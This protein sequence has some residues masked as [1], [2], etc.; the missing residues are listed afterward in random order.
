MTLIVRAIDVGYGYTKFTTAHEGREIR[1]A[2]FPSLAYPAS[3]DPAAS[4]GA[5]RRR[6]VAIPIGPLF[7]EVGPDVLLAADTFRAAQIHDNYIDTPEYLA[8]VR[9]ALRLMKVDHI[10]LLVVGLPVALFVT[11]KSRLEK[12]MTGLHDLGAGKTVQVHKALAM[13]Q[14]NGALIDF[15]TQQDRVVAMEHEFSLVVDPGA[16]TFDWLVAQGMKLSPKRSHSVNRGVNDILQVIADDISVEIG[17]PYTQLE[18][19]DQALRR[20]RSVPIFQ[21]AYSPA[22]MRPVVDSIAR[23]AVGAM[24]RR[25]GECYDVQNVILVG[26]GAYLFKKAIKDAFPRHRITEVKE[27]LYA[28]LR[29]FQIAGRDYA[30]TVLTSGPARQGGG[31]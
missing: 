20:G 15:A 25:A 2:H 28:N 10:D 7:Y 23:Q 12:T 22:R 9:G 5:E 31:R 24:L 19:I 26:G 29:G 18:V 11:H 8:L 17:Q 1:C 6:T 16:R 30:H 27:P 13:A 4:L 21:H 3:R 14:P